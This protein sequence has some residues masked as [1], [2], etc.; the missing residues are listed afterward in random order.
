MPPKSLQE[1]ID[2]EYA[3]QSVPV[4][5]PVSP[6]AES[7]RGKGWF[8]KILLA[9]IIA[10]AAGL[11]AWKIHGNLT[12]APAT[13]RRASGDDRP[14]PVMAAEVQQKEMPIY[15][16]APGTVTAF[17]AVTMRS[18]VDGQLLSENIREGQAVKKGQLL[19]LIDPAPYEAILAQAEGQL[20]KDQAAAA[21]ANAAA[22]RYKALYAAGI[23]SQDQEQ[24]Q[25][26]NA[27]QAA[28]AIQ[29]DNA[30]IQAAKVNLAFTRIVSPIDGVVG[31]R[32]VDPGNIVH[33]ADT[34]GLFVI[35]QLQPITVIFTLPEDQLP[36]VK[37]AMQGTKSLT[38][39]AYDHSATAMLGSGR[40]LT[41]D[42]EI[43][44]TT[45]TDKV[46]GIFENRDGVLFPNQFVNVRL[47]L[48]RDPNALVIPASAL[49][50][51]SVGTFVYV[52]KV[53]DSARGGGTDGKAEVP[54]GEHKNR[55]QVVDDSGGSGQTKS[56]EFQVE[57]RPVTV[58]AME[59]SQV[60]V[61]SGLSVGERVVI[62]GLEK[63][64]DHSAVSLRQ[65]VPGNGEHRSSKHGGQDQSAQQSTDAS[66]EK[67]KHSIARQ[68]NP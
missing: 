2:P 6:V 60:I 18:R 37:K 27:G 67:H 7:K 54:R 40:L 28:G 20:A 39:E 55:K 16:S 56:G 63:L 53:H 19:A 66:T 30:A 4:L 64:K 68:D 57:V 5:A 47:I 49:Q 21:Y 33:A 12:T 13:G 9:L 3:T 43:D 35:T 25:V 38:V 15:L 24:T 52:V 48:K 36:E 34:T 61:G 62:D 42:N 46:K 29:A 14:V 59:G 8:R 10:G 26:A 31:L 41:L 11:A 23:V 22:G 1:L 65:N 51:G 45:G 17:N 58:S 50:V 44:T 32:Q